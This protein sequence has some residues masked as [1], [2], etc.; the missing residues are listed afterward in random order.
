MTASATSHPGLPLRRIAGFESTGYARLHGR[1]VWAGEQAGADHPRNTRRPWQPTRL[2]CDAQRLQRGAAT[3]I[4]L[5]GARPAPGLLAWLGGGPLPFPLDRAAHRFD[6]VRRS[7]QLNDLP[8]FEHAALQLLGLGPGLTPSGDDFVGAICFALVHAPRSRWRA[9]MPALHG[10]I[11]AAAQGA[12]HAISAAL[13]DDLIA[14]GSYRALHEMLAALDGGEAA[15]IDAAAQAL[16]RIGATSGA[17]ML[18]GLLLALSTWHES[19]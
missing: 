7:L 2:D 10:R 5:L 13:L 15:R 1:I 17:D 11:R 9:A 12:T 18:C 3:C 6:A 14:G 16:L 8:A 19:F 4:G